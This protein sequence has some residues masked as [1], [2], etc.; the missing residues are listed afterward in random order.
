MPLKKI[1]A[2]VF[3]LNCQFVFSQNLEFSGGLNRNVFFDYRGDGGHF[4]SNY[5]PD[6]GYSVSASYSDVKIDDLKLLVTVSFQNYNGSIY[7]R[8]GGKTYFLSTEA[9]IQ[10]NVLGLGVYPINLTFLNNFNFRIGG[11]VSFLVYSSTTGT[12]KLF[13]YQI[14]PYSPSPNYDIPIENDSVKI[15]SKIGF[16]ISSQIGYNFQVMDSWYVS[17]QCFFY[18]GLTDEFVNVQAKVKSF[19]YGFQLGVIRKL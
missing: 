7:T 16:G 9:D 3:L 18:L 13:S 6:F 10:R 15:N 4:I 2:F 11:V 12:K 19:R 8:D 14:T 17:P 5:T 1:I